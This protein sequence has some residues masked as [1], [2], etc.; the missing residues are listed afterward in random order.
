M[1]DIFNKIVCFFLGHTPVM[2]E[3]KTWSACVLE[4]TCDRCGT[5]YKTNG[6]VQDAEKR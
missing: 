2:D 6:N 4:A 1:K 5:K 3:G